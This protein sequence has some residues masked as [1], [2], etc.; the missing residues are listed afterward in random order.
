MV[1]WWLNVLRCCLRKLIKEM[2]QHRRK[3]SDILKVGNGPLDF[4]E[5]KSNNQQGNVGSVNGCKSSKG[6]VGCGLK[7]I[8]LAVA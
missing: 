2:I 3:T 5:G 7:W 4:L 6:N 1:L 8:G